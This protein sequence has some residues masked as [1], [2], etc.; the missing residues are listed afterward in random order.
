MSFRL[1]IYYC[2]LCGAW[3]GFLG[4]ALGN[5]L[6]PRP[7][8][9]HTW[10][11]L[12]RGTV[13]G[14]FLGLLVSLVLGLVDGLWNLSLRQVFALMG[15]VGGAMV[16]GATFGA[17]FGLIS[18]SLVTLIESSLGGS[19]F[20]RIL[21]G[22]FQL[23][24]WTLTALL[25]GIALALPQVALS[26][27][28]KKDVRGS[29]KKLYKCAGGGL[30]GGL[31]GGSLALALGFAFATLLSGRN[32]LWSPTSYGFVALGACIGLLIGLAQVILKEAWIKVEAGF[33]P[34][35]EMILVKESTSI[36]R[37]EGS[38]VALFGDPG[39]EKTHAAI[40]LDGGQYYVEDLGT[41]GGTFVNDQQIRGRAP[42]RSGDLI[43]LGGK[44]LLR[45]H[46]RRK[47]TPA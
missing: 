1:F 32:S 22:M 16:F 25:V 33:R 6:S 12:V 20:V 26:L 41:P 30:L 8:P 47:S 42:L 46:E 37:A 15:R 44:S 24:G 28:R 43:R 31:L 10:T 23:I 45:F 13:M 18:Q 2:A 7:D 35:R 5:M 4:W 17:L 40:I 11:I 21:G 14:L 27:L 39:V 34:G 29:L 19:W 3:A 36:G 9:D 38:D